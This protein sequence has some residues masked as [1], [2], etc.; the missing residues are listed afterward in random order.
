MKI[1][2]ELRGTELKVFIERSNWKKTTQPFN[3]EMV[4]VGLVAYIIDDQPI[5]HDAVSRSEPDTH[6]ALMFC[7][8][9]LS[10][11]DLKK[12][13][14]KAR[15]GEPYEVRLGN[16]RFSLRKEFIDAYTLTFYNYCN[17]PVFNHWLSSLPTLEAGFLLQRIKD[18]GRYFSREFSE[19]REFE[20]IKAFV[21]QRF[22]IWHEDTVKE[23]EE[24]VAKG[25]AHCPG[26]DI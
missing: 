21:S 3:K 7:R 4:K 19:F 20:N 12:E 8:G 25:K 11:T 15:F 17:N 10:L 1:A 23:F 13:M 2:A 14:K 16:N 5:F 6:P 22:D 9:E 18:T 26:C 24:A